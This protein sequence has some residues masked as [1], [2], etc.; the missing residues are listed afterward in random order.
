MP[1]DILF[2]PQIVKARIEAYVGAN[3]LIN[4]QLATPDLKLISAN[5]SPDHNEHLLISTRALGLIS[6]R[7][8]YEASY[9]LKQ[10]G[11]IRVLSGV[12]GKSEFKTNYKLYV[13]EELS[14]L[15][16]GGRAQTLNSSTAN[17]KNI[18]FPLWN[19]IT[20]TWDCP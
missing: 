1:N 10:N 17:S 9:K 16:F 13:N 19:P 12:N 3:V 18:A 20:S 6:T 11:D 14:S 8:F 15:G 2:V 4:S 7:A 5:D